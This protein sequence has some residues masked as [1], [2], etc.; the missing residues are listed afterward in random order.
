MLATGQNH[1]ADMGRPKMCHAE[2]DAIRNLG[3]TADL[4]GAWLFVV[5]LGTNESYLLN[6]K[7]C[8]SCQHVIEKCVRTYKLRGVKYS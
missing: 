6:S 4:S 1:L 2:I 5:R 7:P 8:V 3:D